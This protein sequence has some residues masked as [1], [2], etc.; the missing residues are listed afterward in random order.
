M[1]KKKLERITYVTHRLEI[2]FWQATM[3][4]PDRRKR[5][6]PP[7]LD[8]LKRTGL[9]AR[10]GLL[11][12]T[13]FRAGTGL[14]ARAGFRP[15]FGFCLRTS[16]SGYN[17]SRLLAAAGCLFLLLAVCFSFRFFSSEPPNLSQGSASEVYQK[18]LLVVVDKLPG[19]SPHLKGVWLVAIPDEQPVWQLAPVYPASLKGGDEEDAKLARS[20]KLGWH[21]SL[22]KEFSHMLRERGIKWDSLVVLDET[23]LA[24]YIDLMGG[25]GIGSGRL[26]GSQAVTHVLD[27]EISSLKSVLAQAVLIRSLC[28]QS[29]ALFRDVDPL[30]AHERFAGHIY[31]DHTVMDWADEWY[32]MRDYGHGLVCDFPTLERQLSNYR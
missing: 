19:R 8:S 1:T 24:G 23:A 21:G 29:I 13:A 26:G 20:F 25:V 4:I 14:L 22:G 3:P 16:L 27:S 31:S 9:L 30:A 32:Q 11:V 12:S 15:N 18:T 28:H 17:R 10:V 6:A 2:A 7:R 5:P